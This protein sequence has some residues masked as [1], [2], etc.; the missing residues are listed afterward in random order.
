MRGSND[1]WDC[2]TIDADVTSSFAVSL[3]YTSSPS[4]VNMPNEETQLVE[5]A[6]AERIDRALSIVSTSRWSFK[7]R[8]HFTNSRYSRDASRRVRRNEPLPSWLT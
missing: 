2:S 5:G 7:F 6:P 3:R 4:P 8:M 1:R